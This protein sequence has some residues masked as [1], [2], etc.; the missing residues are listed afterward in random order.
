[1][2]I[3]TV[4]ILLTF[5]FCTVSVNGKPEPRASFSLELKGGEPCLLEKRVRILLDG[6]PAN[7]DSPDPWDDHGRAQMLSLLTRGWWCD[8]YPASECALGTFS[9]D[10]DGYL[11]VGQQRYLAAMLHHLSDG[12]KRAFDAVTRGQTLQTRIFRG[13]EDEAAGA[14]PATRE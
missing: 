14:P 2:R 1:M 10:A 7:P 5:I 13:D 11:R 6:E 4:A 8:A 3:L 9:V 12:E